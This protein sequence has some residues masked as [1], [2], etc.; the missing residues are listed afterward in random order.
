MSQNSSA[1]YYQDSQERLQRKLVKDI[2]VFLKR[3]K[4]DSLVVN[5]TNIYQ[6]TKSKDWLSIEKDIMQ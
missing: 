2:K 5:D 1:K 3:R 6:N 4:R